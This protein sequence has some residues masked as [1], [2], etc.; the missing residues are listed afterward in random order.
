GTVG[1]IN[2]FETTGTSR[3]DSLQVELR[4]RF[5][6]HFD[7]EASYVW[8]KVT[9][10][11]SDVF[12]LAGSYA[13]PQNSLTFAGERARANFDVPHRFTYNAIYNFGKSE[14]RGGLNWL[15]NNL[16]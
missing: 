6:N 4:G 12:D 9:D 5:L 13:L 7:L 14:D 2:Q 8:S 16:Q 3:Y 1:A 10:D 15:T 11:V